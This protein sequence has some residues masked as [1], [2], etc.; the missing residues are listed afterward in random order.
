MIEEENKPPKLPGQ[1]DRTYITKPMNHKGRFNAV[2]PQ[3]GKD[4]NILLGSRDPVPLTTQE[5]YKEPP[6]FLTNVEDVRQGQKRFRTMFPDVPVKKGSTDS[7][8]VK[9]I[10]FTFPP[11]KPGF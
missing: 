1:D 7:N 9:K 4:R 3:F 10:T 11:V 2:L 8:T 6:S 5:E